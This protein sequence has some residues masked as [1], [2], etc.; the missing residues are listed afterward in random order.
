MR[1]PTCGCECSNI[2]FGKRLKAARMKAGLSR[3][4]LGEKLGYNEQEIKRWECEWTTPR[5]ANLKLVVGWIEE[6][7]DVL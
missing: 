6:N 3:R 5:P 1:C 4:V 7:N 2:G